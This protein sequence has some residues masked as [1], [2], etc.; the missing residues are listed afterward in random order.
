MKKIL[1]VIM[2]AIVGASLIKKRNKNEIAI[3]TASI[4]KEN[5]IVFVGPS[6][7]AQQLWKLHHKNWPIYVIETTKNWVKIIDAY[8][9][10]GWINKIYVGPAHGLILEE[11]MALSLNSE[12]TEVK[13]LKNSVV[14]FKKFENSFALIE[15]I[16]NGK[17]KTYKIEAA[18]IWLSPKAITK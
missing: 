15:V 1:I 6:K 8:E 3:G 13:L 7:K 14:K 12:I 5:V 4:N 11:T 16:I 17:K 10:T 18:K 9:T 2:I